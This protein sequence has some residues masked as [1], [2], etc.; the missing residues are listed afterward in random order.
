MDDIDNQK[1]IIVGNGRS[2]ITKELQELISKI[3][4]N[5]HSPDI[6]VIS[7]KELESIN[8]EEFKKE[9]KEKAIAERELAIFE[10]IFGPIEDLLPLESR[11]S[12][13]EKYDEAKIKLEACPSRYIHKKSKKRK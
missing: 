5:K 12:Q 1:V 3:H 2:S 7:R 13:Y 4:I 10:C 11:Y 6:L 9:M 8:V